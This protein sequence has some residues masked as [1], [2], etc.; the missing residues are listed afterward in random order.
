MS[1][2]AS[3]IGFSIHEEGAPVDWTLGAFILHM[4]MGPQLESEADIIGNETVMCLSLFA[5]LFLVLVAAF[6]TTWW[7][8]P[9][10]KTVYDL[11]KGHYIVTRIPR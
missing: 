8:K 1:I 4:E 6:Y 7:R 10:M 3:R 2:R 5:V 11:E 9:Q